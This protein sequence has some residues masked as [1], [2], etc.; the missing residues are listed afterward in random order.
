MALQIT[1]RNGRK[2]VTATNARVNF[3]ALLDY[4]KATG[5]T[6]IVTVRGKPRVQIRPKY[7]NESAVT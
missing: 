4:I 7:P 1:E 2:Y 3:G 6:V 5:A